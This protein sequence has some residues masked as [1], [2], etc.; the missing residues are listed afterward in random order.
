LMFFKLYIRISE[1]DD[2]IIEENKSLTA[3]S[4]NQI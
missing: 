4:C 2:V 1:L 3:D